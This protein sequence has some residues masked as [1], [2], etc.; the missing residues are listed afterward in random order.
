MFGLRVSLTQSLTSPEFDG[1][2]AIVKSRLVQN[3]QKESDLEGHI[4]SGAT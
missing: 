2:Q 4:A 1:I 3:E